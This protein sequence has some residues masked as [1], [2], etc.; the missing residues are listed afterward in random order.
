MIDP[1][2][3]GLIRQ[4]RVAVNLQAGGGTPPRHVLEE[5]KGVSFE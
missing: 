1:K 4:A 3:S 2:R 5:G